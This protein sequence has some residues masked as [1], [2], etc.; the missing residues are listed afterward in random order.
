MPLIMGCEVLTVA[1]PSDSGPVHTTF[2]ITGT[3]TAG[4]NSTCTV[5][6]NV[7]AD[8]IGRTGL[9]LLLDIVTEVGRGTIQYYHNN[10][11]MIT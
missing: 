10:T 6:V 11:M 1:S 5:Q 7:T 2:K 8:P 9:G 4:F 3:S